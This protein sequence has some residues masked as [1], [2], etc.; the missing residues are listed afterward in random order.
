MFFCGFLFAN[1]VKINK[2]S[3]NDFDKLLRMAL[4]NKF[5]ILTVRSINKL[6]E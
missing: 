1:K 5:S 2:F 6:M 4:Q 3:K